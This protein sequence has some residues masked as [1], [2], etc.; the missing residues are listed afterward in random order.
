MYGKFLSR[1]KTSGSRFTV[2]LPAKQTQKNEK[3][4]ARQGFR[5]TTSQLHARAMGKKK[6]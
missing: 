6:K 1:A 3:P 2:A 4:T 5:P